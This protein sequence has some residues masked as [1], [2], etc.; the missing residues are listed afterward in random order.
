[1]IKVGLD[2]DNTLIDYDE[3]FYSIALEKGLIP[4]QI[5]KTKI[6]VRKYLKDNGKENIFTLLQGEVYGLH[7][8]RASQSSG[9]MQS[10]KILKENSIELIIISHKTLHPY[11][12]PKYDLHKAAMSWLKKN[13][14]FDQNCLNFRREN[15]FFEITIENKIK[16]IEDS[17]LTYYIDD[18][19]KVLKMINSRIN[20][21]HFNP[22]SEDQRI[23]GI[24]NMK[25]W[26]DLPEIL[27]I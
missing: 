7:I 3:L 1:M 8:K 10:L 2:F 16:R 13:E 21:I 27:D 6:A 11:S 23:D 19:T 5:D 17:G 25:N 26:Q 24:I 20:R 15:V 12:G 9:M 14:F 22:N 4:V 18:L